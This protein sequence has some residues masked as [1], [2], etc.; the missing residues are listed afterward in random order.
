ML[1]PAEESYILSGI[2][3]HSIR[4]DGRHP[5]QYRPNLTIETAVVQQSNGSCKVELGNTH[6]L[7]G[8]KLEIDDI[9]KE[10]ID[11]QEDEET[12][13]EADG[14]NKG[15]VVVNVNWYTLCLVF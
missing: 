12:E 11:Q 3:K 14:S 15:R 9:H 13:A 6:I 4:L 1:S 8:V 10:L 2:N 5:L 7:T